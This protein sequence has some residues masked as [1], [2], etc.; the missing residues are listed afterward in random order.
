[1]VC[2]AWKKGVQAAE[3]AGVRLIF[4]F[5]PP[6]GKKKKRKKRRD[7]V[8]RWRRLW[9]KGACTCHRQ[10]TAS[11]TLPQG[12]KYHA[13]AGAQEEET[14]SPVDNVSS[15]TVCNFLL[16]AEIYDGL[17]S[18]CPSSPPCLVPIKKKKRGGGSQAHNSEKPKIA[19]IVK[20]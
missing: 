7:S 19:A 10:K 9:C 11:K 5:L 2:V 12:H 8:F 20:Q 14:D 16:V 18:W 15:P 17:S 4:F 3:E 13:A 6:S 1:M